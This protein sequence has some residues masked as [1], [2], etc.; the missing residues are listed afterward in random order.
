MLYRALIQTIVRPVAEQVLQRSRRIRHRFPA[1]ENGMIDALESRRLLATFMGTAGNDTITVSSDGAFVHVKVNAGPDQTTT[2]QEIYISAL[3][4]ND[5]VYILPFKAMPQLTQLKIDLGADDDFVSTIN[6][7]TAT[8]SLDDF[9][10]QADV[11]GGTGTNSILLND[12]NGTAARNYVFTTVGWFGS[13]PAISVGSTD[14]VYTQVQNITLTEGSFDDSTYFGIKTAGTSVNVN[15]G[16]GVDTFSCQDYGGF[17]AADTILDGGGGT[18]TL[19]FSSSNLNPATIGVSGSTISGQQTSYT[20]SRCVDLIV[21]PSGPL[22]LNVNGPSVTN[23]TIYSTGSTINLN[24]TPRTTTV[25]GDSGTA[26]NLNDTAFAAGLTYTMNTTQIT[27]NAQEINYDNVPTI[28]FHAGSGNDRMYFDGIASGTTVNAHGNNGNDLIS[29]GNNSTFA[30]SLLG[31]ASVSGD[32]GADEVDW[33]SPDSAAISATMTASAFSLLGHTYSYGTF[34]NILL[35]FLNTAGLTLAIQSISTPTWAV[36]GNGPDTFNIGNGNLSA[37]IAAP[38]TVAGG[39]GDDKLILDDHSTSTGGSYQFGAQDT[40]LF[41]GH[42]IYLSTIEHTNLTSGSGYDVVDVNGVFADLSVSTGG[43]NDAVSVKASNGFVTVDTGPETNDPFTTPIFDSITANVDSFQSGDA[44]GFVRIAKNDLVG[45]LGVFASAGSVGQ[46]KIDSGATLAIANFLTFNG[47]TIDLAGG[48]LL[49][50]A[51]VSG[52]TPAQMRN[53]IINGRNGGAWNGAGG[54][55]IAA[56]NSSLAAGSAALDG[57]GYGLGSQIAIS[58]TGGFNIAPGD[59]LF[60]Y[61]LEGDANLNGAVNAADLGVLSLN[62]QGNSKVFSQADFNYD[63]KVDLWDLYGLSKNFNQT[64]PPASAAP[65][66]LPLPTRAPTRSAT[67][68]IDLVQ[69]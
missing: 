61:T 39:N 12:T 8:A 33:L 64:L 6:P 15:A 20:Y 30:S 14:I 43:G 66:A 52:P 48:S 3:G 10:F 42:P 19:D 68:T 65:V 26:L 56:M 60:R 4:G 16:G 55:G 37:D 40:F 27:R 41:N 29:F 36:A 51:G 44:P 34:E 49:T 25:H 13:G 67:R 1:K 11:V 45:S 21:R 5:A 24:S 9:A 7:N 57:V 47:G 28:T 38:I 59:T 23:A 54:P 69:V 63:N 32:A 46:V 50:R 18:D 2:E 35:N 17:T 22:T 53:A 62:W 31:N 58:S